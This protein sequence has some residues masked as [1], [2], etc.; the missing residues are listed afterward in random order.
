MHLS[1]VRKL[2]QYVQSF[3]LRS[4]PK[5]QDDGGIDF[6][7]RLKTCAS[8][9]PGEIVVC[10]KNHER[11]RLETPLGDFY[12][13]GGLPKAKIDFGGGKSLGVTTE[14]AAMGGGGVSKRV[15]VTG[16]IKF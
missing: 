15:M 7:V 10:A 2:K 8:G 5:A 16:A 1:V 4:L 14:S 3:D 13:K 11:N 6:H 9:E 12:G